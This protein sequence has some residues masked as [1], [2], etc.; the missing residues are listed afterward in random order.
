[1]KAK[2][3]FIKESEI[4]SQAD[5]MLQKIWVNEILFTWQWWLLVVIFLLPWIVWWKLIDKKRIFEILTYGLMVSLMTIS[6]DAIGVEYDFWE[7]HYQLIPLLDVL[8][9]FDISVLMVTYMLFYQYIQS[10]KW[11]II[12]HI[13]IAGIFAF[14]AEP[15]LVQLG[16]YQLLKWKYI[17]SFPI[18]IVIAIF[19]RWV[20]GLLKRL[21]FN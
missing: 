21:S 9:V 13:V 5:K 19:I 3:S 11:F 7:Y 2:S 10:W 17:Y 15:I 8:I 4:Q 14:I 1:M 16:Y 20:N 12:G 6:F 18:Y